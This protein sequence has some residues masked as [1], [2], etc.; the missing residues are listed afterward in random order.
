[1]YLH[2]KGEGKKNSSQFVRQPKFGFIVSQQWLKNGKTN[3][4]CLINATQ[5]WQPTASKICNI[6][7]SHSKRAELTQAD[8]HW[9][10]YIALN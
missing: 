9:E 2:P 8:V 1:M 4:R 5:W 10:K 6:H 7:Q 3:G